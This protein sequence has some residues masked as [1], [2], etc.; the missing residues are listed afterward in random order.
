MGDDDKFSFSVFNQSGDVV[1]S[2]LDFVRLG[3]L[4]LF[5]VFLFL[6][7]VSK[8]V[9]FLLSCLW[10][11]LSEKFEE[12]FDFVEGESV[13]ELVNHRRYLESLIKNSSLSLELDVLRPPHHSCN[14]SF[15]HHISSYGVVSGSLL[16]Q[17]GVLVLSDL[18][19][20]VLFSFWHWGFIKN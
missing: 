13:S 20:H 14:I 19:A 1:E 16:E 18:L 4:D 9:F 15:V 11:V 7:F 8:S 3:F 12:R 2:E 10:F 6:G 5:F 17:V